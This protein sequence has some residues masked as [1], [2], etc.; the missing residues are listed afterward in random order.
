[1]TALVD[2]G[3]FFA[4]YSLRDEHHLDSLAL[5]IHLLEGKWGQGYVTDHILDEILTLLKCRVSGETA[6]AFIES[7]IDTGAVRVLYLNEDDENEALLLFKENVVKKGFSYTD[8][9]TIAAMRRY[10]IGF[11]LSFD[12]RS[13][14]WLVERIIGPSY[15]NALPENERDRILKMVEKYKARHGGEHGKSLNV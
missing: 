14:S 13:F 12:Q 7:V 9:T 4:F 15:W 1:M 8:A 5:V 10:K 3:V 11:L 6:K 2:T